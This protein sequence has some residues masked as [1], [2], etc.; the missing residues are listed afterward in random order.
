MDQD[1]F[2][3]GEMVMFSCSENMT[4]VGNETLFCEDGEFGP[5]PFCMN[6]E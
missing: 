2:F 1:V 6:L 5:V 3:D 4:L